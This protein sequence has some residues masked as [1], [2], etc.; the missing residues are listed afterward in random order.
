[1]VMKAETEHQKTEDRWAKRDA[2]SNNP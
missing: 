1:M 2:R